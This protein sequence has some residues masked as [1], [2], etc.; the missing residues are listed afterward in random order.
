MELKNLVLP[1]LLVPGLVTQHR[2]HGLL[3]G[4]LIRIEQRCILTLL[5]WRHFTLTVAGVTQLQIL[6]DV[7]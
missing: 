2:L 6:K 3:D 1:I 7:S 5:Q 4:K